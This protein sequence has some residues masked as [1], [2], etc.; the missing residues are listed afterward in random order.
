MRSRFL[1]AFPAAASLITLAGCPNREVSRVDPAQ[2]LVEVKELPVN[3]NRKVDLLFV[4]DNSGSMEKNQANLKRNF[5]DFINVLRNI[6]DGNGGVSLP[7][8]HIGV[9]TSDA[10]CGSNNG[11][12]G[13][14]QTKDFSAGGAG[15]TCAA[16]Q[17]NQ[18]ISDVAG[19]GGAREVNYSGEL[20]DAFTCIASTGINGCGFEQHLESMKRAI[21]KA[22]TGA[23]NNGFL[24]EDAYLAVVILADE[25]DCS[26][27]SADL[28]DSSANPYGTRD[29]F[30]CFEYGVT[31][32]QEARPSGQTTGPEPA[33]TL[34]GC[35]PNPDAELIRPIDT[36]INFLRD[37]VKDNPR[38]VIVA[39]IQGNP[40]SVTIGRQGADENNPGWF[41]LNYSCSV[42]DGG[43]TYTAAPG[44]RLDAF[45]RA[46]VDRNYSTTIC[47][48]D[49]SDGLVGIATLIGGV[50]GNPCIQGVLA[51]KDCNADGLQAECAVSYAAD[52]GQ[53]TPQTMPQCDATAS[54][55][56]CWGLEADTDCANP[57]AGDLAIKLE[58]PGT[59]P[60]DTI[61]SV[62]CATVDPENP[63][64]E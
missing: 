20:A 34:T 3:L 49:L 39:T 43:E 41:K 26:A 2:D 32:D 11:D 60:A 63:S 59:P 44:I 62:Q 13:L 36:F 23:A 40:D 25:D 16:L 30:R 19:V 51:D 37:D 8:V 38:D 57:A 27:A 5:D 29:S 28:F 33:E 18:F 56:P 31:C 17:G 9:V 55:K 58:W 6:P 50:I 12:D 48:G 53:G 35:T 1:V 4:I 47:D 61:V 10:G 15:V 14:L 64:C 45:R 7:D 42:P 52:D 54:N 46:F 21:T 24:R 22:K